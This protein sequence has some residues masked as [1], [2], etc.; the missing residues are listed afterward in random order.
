MPQGPPSPAV[1]IE[2]TAVCIAAAMILAPTPAVLKKPPCPVSESSATF[3]FSNKMSMPAR[4]APSAVNNWARMK[5]SKV[6][7]AF[8]VLTKSG[9]PLAKPVID[10]PEM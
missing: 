2:L 6:K 10:S 5:F 8:C 7:F 4:K 9:R 1:F 3:S